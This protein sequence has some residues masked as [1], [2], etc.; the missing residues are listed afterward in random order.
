MIEPELGRR[1]LVDAIVAAL[2]YHPHVNNVLTHVSGGQWPRVD[3][4]LAVIFDRQTTADDLSPLARNVVDLL[5]AE[6]GVTGR[7]LKP[8]FRDALARLLPSEAGHSLWNHIVRLSLELQ[9]ARDSGVA[10]TRSTNGGQ[11]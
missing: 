11:R 7:I 4:A 9:A 5:C 3:Q 6:R 8:Y 10:I 1:A 2:R